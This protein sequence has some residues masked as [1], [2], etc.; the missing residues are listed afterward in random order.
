MMHARPPRLELEP[1]MVVDEEWL[2]LGGFLPADL[3][4]AARRLA[5][6]NALL[7]EIPAS[8]PVPAPQGIDYRDANGWLLAGVLFALALLAVLP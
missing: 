3:R 6:I 2:R 4:S 7:D 5:D 1:T 8:E